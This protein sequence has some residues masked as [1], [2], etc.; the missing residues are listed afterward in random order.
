MFKYLIPFIILSYG[1]LNSQNK[2]QFGVGNIFRF[3][4]I[5]FKDY[6]SLKEIYN[7]E[8]IYQDE[9]LDRN[10]KIYFTKSNKFLNI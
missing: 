7:Q 5:E 6:N 1:I 4:E 10:L 3:I 9:I 2:E 8:K